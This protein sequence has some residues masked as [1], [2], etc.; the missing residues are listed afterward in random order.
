[1]GIP[2]HNTFFLRGQDATIRPGDLY[3]PISLVRSE[4][5]PDGV[6][7]YNENLK[8]YAKAWASVD[9]KKR[10]VLDGTGQRL[11]I[12]HYFTIRERKDL[13]IE[14]QDLIIFKNKI[15]RIVAVEDLYPDQINRRYT[16]LCAFEEGNYKDRD[17]TVTDKGRIIPN[18]GID[19]TDDN[20]LWSY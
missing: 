11:E 9:L 12:E 1:M 2:K 20:P 17:V 4:L 8:P 19:K 5:T 6:V 10:W 14:S 16:V 18:T 15:F 7:G 3:N 13:S